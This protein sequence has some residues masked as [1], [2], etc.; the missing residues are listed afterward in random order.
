M[1]GERAR[2]R[3][4]REHRRDLVRREA[5]EIAVLIAMLIDDIDVA[6]P[7]RRCGAANAA[8]AAEEQE[9]VGDA[10]TALRGARE[11]IA[12]MLASR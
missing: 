2:A 10:R 3:T 11:A 8:Y 9:R 4:L 6:W 12:R 1:T 5:R 7:E